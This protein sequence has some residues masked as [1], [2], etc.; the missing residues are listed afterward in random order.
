MFF[1]GMAS[2]FAIFAILSLIAD[3]NEEFLQRVFL[4]VFKKSGRK[5]YNSRREGK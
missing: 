5:G 3:N 1:I 2:I 4:T